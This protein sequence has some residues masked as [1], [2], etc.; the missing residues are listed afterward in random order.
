MEL[1]SFTL[2]DD[3]EKPVKDSTKVN[4]DTPVKAFKLD[5]GN[6]PEKTQGVSIPT[7]QHSFKNDVTDSQAKDIG[8]Y[9][10]TDDV[11]KK[12]HDNQSNFERLGNTLGRIVTQT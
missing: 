6:L 8:D 12:L 7:E 3:K 4:D 11:V 10:R 2:E 5:W 1:D 9:F